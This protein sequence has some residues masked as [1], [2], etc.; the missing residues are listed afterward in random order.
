M[1]ASAQGHH[2]LAG[3]ESGLSVAPLLGLRPPEPVERPREL[4]GAEG[5]AGAV[6]G[7]EPT[8]TTET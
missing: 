8:L 6:P 1:E 5:G 4:D 7:F 3:L 2:F